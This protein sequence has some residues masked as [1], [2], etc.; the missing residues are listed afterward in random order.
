MVDNH[1][2]SYLRVEDKVFGRAHLLI[3]RVGL[4][5]DAGGVMSVVAAEDC[6]GNVGTGEIHVH[7]AVPCRVQPRHG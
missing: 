4:E 6:G 7:R 3:V 5:V 2:L 1:R